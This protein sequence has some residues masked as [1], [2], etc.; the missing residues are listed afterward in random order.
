MKN[1]NQKMV[2]TRLPGGNDSVAFDQSSKA[3]FRRG[4]TATFF[5]GAMFLASS[6]ASVQAVPA[7][8]LVA[9]GDVTEF[10]GDA[11]TTLLLF[12]VT[13]TSTEI[14]TDT[15][16]VDYAASDGACNAGSGP[17]TAT[18]ASIVRVEYCLF[19]QYS[20]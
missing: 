10:E 1:D 20:W 4:L 15:I 7:H 17:C 16:T 14:I 19:I 6:M 9:L 13:V 11:G 8:P 2:L 18:V 5:I 12:P 3:I